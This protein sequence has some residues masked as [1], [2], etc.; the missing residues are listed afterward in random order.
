[1]HDIHQKGIESPANKQDM[2]KTRNDGFR[3]S[4]GKKSCEYVVWVENS[5]T[6]I[7]MI[8]PEWNCRVGALCKTGGYEIM[9]GLPQRGKTCPTRQKSFSQYQSR[10]KKKRRK[11]CR[12]QTPSKVLSS[13][14]KLLSVPRTLTLHWTVTRV[15]TGSKFFFCVQLRHSFVSLKR[16]CHYHSPPQAFFQA[17]LLRIEKSLS[18][19]V[20]NLN[21][22][23]PTWLTIDWARSRDIQRDTLRIVSSLKSLSLSL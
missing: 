4:L 23:R 15:D 3:N 13:T 6:T 10:G 11:S 20:P 7:E 18:C 1:M 21:G 19:A 14:L 17:K 12:G 22:T 5:F 16:C 2:I 9:N 8:S